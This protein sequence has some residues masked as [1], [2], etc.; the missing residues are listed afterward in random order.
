MGSHPA[1]PVPTTAAGRDGLAAFLAAPE[2]ALVAL[3]FDGTLA[4][5]VPNPE[6]SRPHPDVPPALTRLAPLIGGLAV[7]T[8]R[9]AADAARLGGF[10]ALRGTPGFDRFTVLG[11]YG[12]ERWTALDGRLTTPPA[13]PGVMAARADLPGIVRDALPSD[14][15]HIEDK[16]GALAVH[17]RRAA[18]PE[19]ALEALREPLILLAAR[20]ALT[21]EPGRRVL[22]LRPPGTDKGAALA[23]LVRSARPSVV[24]YAGDDLGD[25]AAFEALVKLRDNGLPGVRVCSGSTEVPALVEACD[26]VVDGPAGVAALLSGLAD[27][28]AGTGDGNRADAG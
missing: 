18:D 20:H 7:I 23:E 28:V 3:D 6:D 22:E 25:L 12:A 1:L 4:P 17:T 8:G 15:V 5:I 14:R 11:A 13:H 27:A 9:A 16:G 2:R 19:A 24:L 21:V 26:L 10:E